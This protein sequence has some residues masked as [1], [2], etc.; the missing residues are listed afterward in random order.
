M[1]GPLL[2]LAYAQEAPAE[3][4]LPPLTRDPALLEFVQAPYPEAAKAA[5]IEGTVILAIEI[6]AQGAVTRVEV[7]QSAGHGFDEAAV[8][9]AR[10]F[11]FSPAEDAAGPV[12]VAIEF[13]YGFVL[14]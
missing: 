14:D 13:A 4:E 5:K 9:A 3:A 8:E 2:S 7:A 12:P 1:I 6:D 10:A 11:K